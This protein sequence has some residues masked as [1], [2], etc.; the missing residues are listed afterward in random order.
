MNDNTKKSKAKAAGV[1][2]GIVLSADNTVMTAFGKGNAAILEKRITG[3][4]IESLSEP[5]YFGFSPKHGSMTGNR[6]ER[7]AEKREAYFREHPDARAKYETAHPVKGTAGATGLPT[8]YVVHPKRIPVPGDIERNNPLLAAPTDQIRAKP[9]LERKVFGQTFDDTLHV[10]IAYAILD[11]NKIFTPHIV[12][13]VHVLNSLDR[14]GLS[15]REDYLGGRFFDTPKD[16][17]EWKIQKHLFA[18]YKRLALPYLG[19]FGD[20]FKLPKQKAP[21]FEHQR[22]HD[23]MWNTLTIIQRMRLAV[24]H[25][26]D[27]DGKDETAIFNPE[28]H[29]ERET[30]DLIRTVYADRIHELNTRFIAHNGKSNL[31]I[32]FHYYGADTDDAKAQIT[33][34]FYQFVVCKAN[35]NM[36]FSLRTVREE[37][38]R[39]DGDGEKLASD[40]YSSVRHKLYSLLDFIVWRHFK[41]ARR[42]QT[43][44]FII[45]QLRAS[46][47][48]ASK[49]EIYR[50]AAT[51]AWSALKRNILEKILP[52]IGLIQNSAK[53]GIDAG[54]EKKLTDAL[55]PVKITA[56]NTS[57]FSQMVYFVSRFLDGKEINDL[58][59]TLIHAFENI[60]SFREVERGL[61]AKGELSGVAPFH[62]D[63]A[64]FETSGEIAGELRVVNSFARMSRE[65]PHTKL[66]QYLDAARVL[67]IP[68]K[69][70]DDNETEKDYVT[71]LLRLAEKETKG[72]KSFR[73]FIAKNV[74]ESTRFNYIVR[75]AH[76]ATLKRLATPTLLRFVLGRIWDN[77]PSADKPAGIIARY[78]E[79][80]GGDRAGSKENQINALVAALTGITFETFMNVKQKPGKDDK[81]V[82][83]KE[84]LLALVRLYLI[85]LY[86]IVKNLVYVNARYVIAI[87]R[88]EADSALHGKDITQDKTRDNTWLVRK[89]LDERWLN[90]RASGHLQNNLDPAR[91]NDDLFDAY[92]NAVAHLGVLA[93]AADAHGKMKAVPSWFALYHFVMQTACIPGRLLK[94]ESYDEAR[95]RDKAAYEKIWRAYY[96]EA[97]R[98]PAAERRGEFCKDLL[99]S[100]NAPFGYNLSRYKNLSMAI[101]FDKNE[102][103]PQHEA[104]AGDESAD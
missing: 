94:P 80:L 9:L 24:V 72:E 58:L 78:T 54:E 52:R 64:L 76:P 40:T 86:H 56:E 28:T 33:R 35:K 88:L 63:Y 31:P 3:E 4:T 59:T 36:G 23:E 29:F 47:D 65:M 70:D 91:Y 71:R 2:S 68:P 92:R 16:E 99:W 14:S 51:A 67:G 104:P 34:D 11:I 102:A 19:Y 37:M 45:A 83:E 44:E 39:L 49:Q 90:A 41:E 42:G 46:T 97:G 6:R 13:L 95:G 18:E 8:S 26:K 1:K 100:L 50:R 98:I 103:P 77:D 38:L 62:A 48:D 10:Q 43:P 25:G 66:E 30:C 93:C 79:R 55:A 15:S 87:Q 12:S 27:R 84:R 82:K 7:R 73:N 32:L 75:Y 20:A 96:G 5:E 89:A 69:P 53:L 17:S 85:C 21:A 57:L 74:I 22:F 101:L 61:V 60:Q 81:E